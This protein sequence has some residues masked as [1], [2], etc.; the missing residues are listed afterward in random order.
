M[1]QNCDAFNYTSAVFYRSACFFN[2]F[3]LQDVFMLSDTTVLNTRVVADILKKGFTRIPVYSG[4]RNTVVALLNVKVRFQSQL[5]LYTLEGIL[6]KSPLLTLS[7]IFLE[8][9]ILMVTIFKLCRL[10]RLLYVI[11][12]WGRLCIANIS[13]PHNS[14][15]GLIA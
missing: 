11:V 1:L 5:F 12:L 15:H 10:K 3:C 13:C 7:I 4:D 6:S 9:A 8:T 14:H 2:S